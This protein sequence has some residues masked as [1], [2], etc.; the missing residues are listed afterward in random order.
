MASKKKTGTKEWASHNITIV[1]GC[2]YA[3]R[4]CYGREMA[5]RFGRIQTPGE[6]A[7]PHLRH[8]EVA[9]SRRKLDGIVM[10]QSVSDITPEFIEPCLDVLAK[11]LAAGNKVL[12]VTKPSRPC[13]RILCGTFSGYRDRIVLRFTIGSVHDE[14]LKFWEPGAPGFLERKYCLEDAFYNGFATSVSAEPYLDTSVEYL[15]EQLAPYVTQDFWIGKLRN[16]S[17][18]VDLSGITR[19]RKEIFIDPLLDAQTGGAVRLLYE[20]LNGKPHIKWKD[21]IRKVVERI[22]K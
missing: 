6:W 18:R 8:K 20:R 15:Y 12:I 11:L 5:L 21:S 19:Q 3:C 14:V 22:P 4:Y 17:K 13:V 10:F 2:E 16:L 1:S 9:K 7:K